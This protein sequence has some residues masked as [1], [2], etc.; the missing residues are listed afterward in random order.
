MFSLCSC[1]LQ[2]ML[3]Y[4]KNK[5]HTCEITVVSNLSDSID[6]IMFPVA[7][8][9]QRLSVALITKRFL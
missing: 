8:E 3:V 4:W 2:E 7:K 1:S 5:S 9:K 6:F